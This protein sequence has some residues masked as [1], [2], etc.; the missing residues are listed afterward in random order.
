LAQPASPAAR[1]T[2]A[3][4]VKTGLSVPRL[5]RRPPPRLVPTPRTSTPAST[6]SVTLERNPANCINLYNTASTS[7]SG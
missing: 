3:M 7:W 6:G 1:T 4:P 2:T 5:N